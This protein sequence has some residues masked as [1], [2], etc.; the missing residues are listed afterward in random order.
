MPARLFIAFARCDKMDSLRREAFDKS[1]K[2][3]ID[4][5]EFLQGIPPAKI[6]FFADSLVVR[7]S[8]LRA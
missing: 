2:S 7:A 5:T 6:N 1:R 4:E 3:E 8:E